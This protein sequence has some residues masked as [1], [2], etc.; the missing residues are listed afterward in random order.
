MAYSSN[1]LIEASD[2]NNFINGANQINTVW[3]TGTGDVG[4]GQTALSTVSAPNVVT[5]TQWTNLLNAVT[6]ARAHQTG[7]PNITGFGSVAAGD[8]INFLSTLQSQINS[9]YSNRL[10]Y[11][12][13]GS[14]A[15]GGTMTRLVSSTTGLGTW[16]VIDAC[17]LFDSADQAR[18]FF[19]AG[20]QLNFIVGF[21]SGNGSGSTQSL[22]RLITGIGGM[23]MYSLTNS[24]CLGSGITLNTNNSD[25]G[26]Y[27]LTTTPQT[28]I[29]TTD[30]TASYTGSNS[31]LQLFSYDGTTTNGSKGFFVVFRLLYDVDD[32]T[33]D[34]TISLNITHRIDVVSPST[35]Y[36]TN[37]WGAALRGAY[38]W[39]DVFNR[40][41]LGQSTGANC[42]LSADVSTAGPFNN[43]V[44]MKMTQTGNDPYTFTY[45]AFSTNLGQAAQGQVW[46][47]TY[48]IRGSG[49]FIVE[50]AWIA[51]ANSSGGYLAGGSSTANFTI[52]TS[53]QK[54]TT[55]HTITNPSTAYVQV[56]L[57]GTNTYS[58]SPSDVWWD[59]LTLERVS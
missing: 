2:Y 12:S 4:Y 59:H 57:D 31:A 16:Q 24:G 51:E 34:D 6:N 39:N 18:Y 44:P 50:G 52:N 17:V 36:L 55:T 27:D 30:T 33:W 43:S 29:F 49:T 48:W 20:G 47:L 37:S 3:A 14:T 11:G 1:G 56:R 10:I 5:A 22:Q 9:A 15:T 28:V 38:T 19:N 42:T 23:Y 13:Q 8:T 46:K 32:K 26:Y 25:I 21:N 7:N 41:N 54:I 35:T 58:G 40:F 53:W 45:N